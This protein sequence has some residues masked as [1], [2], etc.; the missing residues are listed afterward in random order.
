M[1]GEKGLGSID[2]DILLILVYFLY[3][4]QPVFNLGIDIGC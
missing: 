2:F 3:H 1:W 4:F